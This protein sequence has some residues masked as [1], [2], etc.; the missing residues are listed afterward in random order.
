MRRATG[1]SAA[2]RDA[3]YARAQ[4]RCEVCGDSTGPFQLHHRRARGMGGTRR[5]DTNSPANLLLLCSYD[6]RA[7]ESFRDLARAEGRL[8]SQ[9][10]DP[11][12]VHVRLGRTWQY[13]TAD[14][15]YA[16][17]PDRDECTD[18][19]PCPSCPKEAS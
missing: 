1:P 3:V 7:I 4:Y 16:C 18:D 11:A 13:L 6:H 9:H 8:V 17:A 5:I 15:R 2:A 10:H 12:E 19:S 14:G